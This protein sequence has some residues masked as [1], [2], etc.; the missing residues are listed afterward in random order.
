MATRIEITG[1]GPTAEPLDVP[2]EVT[3]GDQTFEM[4]PGIEGAI[5][6][7]PDEG[8]FWPVGQVEGDGGL[9][10][11]TVTAK[12]PSALQRALGVDAPAALGNIAATR[13]S[14]IV[15]SPIQAACY[16]YMDHYYLGAPGALRISK[17]SGSG[18]ANLTPEQVE[19]LRDQALDMGDIRK[20]PDADGVGG[21][22]VVSHDRINAE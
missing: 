8:P 10:D 7:R 12:E 4:P 16:R 18:T 6:Y 2:L 17:E 11:V 21:Q 9:V 1:P 22:R 5:P 3:V 15:V 20:M 14:D 19:V 13:L